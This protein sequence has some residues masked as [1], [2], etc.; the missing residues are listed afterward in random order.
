MAD[1]VRMIGAL[2]SFMS[3]ALP[4][5][6]FSLAGGG[7]LQGVCLWRII[8]GRPDNEHGRSEWWAAG[9]AVC[10]ATAAWMA[11]A[12]LLFP[13]LF[14]VSP[15]V[16]GLIL[17]GIQWWALAQTRPGR[18][19]GDQ[20]ASDGDAPIAPVA[21]L[22]PPERGYRLP[23]LL[24]VPALI[25]LACTTAWACKRLPA[26]PADAWKASHSDTTPPLSTTG[27]GSPATTERTSAAPTPTTRA[28]VAADLSL[29]D[30]APAQVRVVVGGFD[31]AMGN[32]FAEVRATNVSGVRCALRGRTGLILGQ[33]GQKIS[34]AVRPMGDDQPATL[35][36]GIPL[37]PGTSASARLAWPGYRNGA[38]QTKPQNVSIVLGA[39]ETAHDVR[40]E[41]GHSDGYVAELGP[42]PFDIKAGVPGGAVIFIGRWRSE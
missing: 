24:W 27:Q 23:A 32:S 8:L 17:P 33:G 14:V 15:L 11:L 7:V 21:G 29:A 31:G 34:L 28:M 22:A 39:A 4:A 37:G 1:A 9:G 42:A 6:V 13:V 2:T 36:Q 16:A 20:P 5:A 35:P 12:A 26:P 40:L 41:G 25:A 38:D 30:C 19:A 18:W 10:A 3:D